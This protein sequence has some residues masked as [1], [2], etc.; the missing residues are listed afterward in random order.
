M[1]AIWFPDDPANGSDPV[2]SAVPSDRR[3]LLHA[4]VAPES[5]LGPAGA[6][7]YRVDIALQGV[8]ETP[9]F[10]D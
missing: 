9:F 5:N 3:S 1:T 6:T 8:A 2:L 4:A 10:E 7:C